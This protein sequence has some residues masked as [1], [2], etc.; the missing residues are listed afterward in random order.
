[1]HGLSL[2]LE[3][4]IANSV[5][6]SNFDRVVFHSHRLVM[7]GLTIVQ[8]TIFAAGFLMMYHAHE[9]TLTLEFSN[10]GIFYDVL[11]L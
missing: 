6:K 11:N 9:S 1:M 7:Y 8:Y 3:A 5:F 4:E 10:I 2:E